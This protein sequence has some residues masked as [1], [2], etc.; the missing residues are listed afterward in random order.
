MRKFKDFIRSLDRNLRLFKALKI[1]FQICH[2]L[3][4]CNNPYTQIESLRSLF[5]TLRMPYRQS[6]FTI[7]SKAGMWNRMKYRPNYAAPATEPR[8]WSWELS[9]LPLCHDIAKSPGHWVLKCKDNTRLFLTRWKLYD[10]LR[11]NNSLIT[12]IT[13]RE[14]VVRLKMWD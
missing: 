7:K 1:S 13:A 8:S 12:L 14:H 4:P 2:F 11:E 3:K 5:F 6:G 9:L 10:S